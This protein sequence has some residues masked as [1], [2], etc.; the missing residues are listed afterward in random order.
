MKEQTHFH[1][2]TPCHENWDNMTQQ[3]KGRFCASCAK[4]VVD[5]SLMSDQQVLNF[6]KTA[7]GKVCGRFANDQLQ[8]PMIEAPKQKK[9]VWWIAAMMPLLLMFGKANAQ[10]KKIKTTKGEPAL[11]IPD[12]RQEIMGKVAP[13]IRVATDTVAEQTTSTENCLRTVGDTI[14]TTLPN[15]LTIKGTIIDAKSGEHIY[16]ASVLIKDSK[17]GVATD[18]NGNF[19]LSV[20]QDQKL[21]TITI[22]Y[23]GYETKE[24]NLKKDALAIISKIDKTGNIEQITLKSEMLLLEEAVSG[25]VVIVSCKRPKHIDTAKTTIKKILNAQ[26]FK[27]FPNPIEKGSILKLEIKKK[28][29]YSVQILDNNGSLILVQDFHSLN[30]N[31]LMEITI[32]PYVLPGIYYIR[33]LDNNKKKQYTDKLV[34]Q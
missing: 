32:P 14:L 29:D 6:F 26:E 22:S 23:I 15:Y 7:T 34:V 21:P 27:I 3:D 33:L 28:G 11:I 5:F 12:N 17:I 30:D 1:I 16:G 4:Q 18:I 13:G 10:K 8:R 25:D 31:S 19:S 9:K 2:P 24:I 20:K